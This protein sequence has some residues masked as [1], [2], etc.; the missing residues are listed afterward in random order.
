[1]SQALER[2]KEEAR[3]PGHRAW[4]KNFPG[5]GPSQVP[6]AGALLSLTDLLTPFHKAATPTHNRR[7]TPRYLQNSELGHTQYGDG[8]EAKVG[9]PSGTPELPAWGE[10][11]YHHAPLHREM[12]LSL[13]L[14]H[15]HPGPCQRQRAQKQQQS[16]GK[17]EKGEARQRSG[18][19]NPSRE[20]LGVGLCSKAL[21][22]APLSHDTSLT[23]H[24]FKEKITKN[25]KTTTTVH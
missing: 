22:T 4:R 3:T 15:W 10:E 13:T 2:S 21:M 11:S 6:G 1:M 17:G 12:H 20:A 9:H 25:F 24:R 8:Q 14:L 18:S 16:Q 19:E 5:H 7:A 23:E